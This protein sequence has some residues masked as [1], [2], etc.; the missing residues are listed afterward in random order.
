MDKINIIKEAFLNRKHDCNFLASR[1]GMIIPPQIKEKE[2][3]FLSNAHYYEAVLNRDPGDLYVFSRYTL[4]NISTINTY[5]SKFTDLELFSIFGCY[6]FY[7]SRPELLDRLIGS[8]NGLEFFAILEENTKDFLVLRYGNSIKSSIYS[9]KNNSTF[10]MLL[11][12]LRLDRLSELRNIVNVYRNKK[13]VDSMLD[14]ID[15]RID[16]EKKWL[17][18]M[19]PPCKKWL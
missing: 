3:Y 7:S 18:R 9:S 6:V 8:L 1:I 19:F 5:L 4:V 2:K 13:G 17:I 10:K 15:E 16:R 14:M 11:N 12:D